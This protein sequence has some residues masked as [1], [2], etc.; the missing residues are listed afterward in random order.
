VTR[1]ATIET[2]IIL[3]AVSTL[4]GPERAVTG[5]NSIDLHWDDLGGGRKQRRNDRRN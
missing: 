2:K 3:K 1:F 5:T 4:L